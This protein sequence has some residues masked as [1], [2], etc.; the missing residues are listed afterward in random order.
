[1]AV[2]LHDLCGADPSRRFSPYCWRVRM[3]LAHKG[4]PHETRPWRFTEKDAIA[5]AGTDKV[6]V[7]RHGDQM[8][9]ESWRILEYLE[10]HWPGAPSLFGGEGGRALARF[11]NTWSDAVMMPGLVRLIVSDIP[12]H[13]APADAEYFI[14][15]REARFGKPLSELTADRDRAV[16]AFRR[17]LHP[18]RM[19]LR[20]RPWLSGLTAGA[21]DYIVF[22]PLQ[23]ARCVSA[24]PVLTPDDPIH[25]WRGRLLDAFGGL[26]RSAPAEDQ[27]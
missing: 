13:L 10:D 23:W 17:D 4:I 9:H 5:D 27:T 6:P 3:A 26:A 12:A 20:E 1:M 14:R 8:V 11:V 18:L 22:G 2:I 24:F 21:A 16:E 25:A 15:T 19:V 7:L